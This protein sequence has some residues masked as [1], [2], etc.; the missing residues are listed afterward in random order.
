MLIQIYILI[1]MMQRCSCADITYTVS[2]GKSP[3]NY[4]GN[5][6]A[7]SEIARDQD[8]NLITFSQLQQ[9]NSGSSVLFRVTKKTGKLY[10]METLD[11]ETICK[12]NKECFQILDI[13]IQKKA[14]HH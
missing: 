12:R 1:S 2:E 3:G 4:I 7:D 6:A 5:I 10:T 8:L 13:A 14:F 11:A 9:S